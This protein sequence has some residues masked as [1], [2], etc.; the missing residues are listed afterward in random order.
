MT[1]FITGTGT[2]IGKTWVSCAILRALRAG[3]ATP[4][5]LKPVMSGFDPDHLASS[6]AGALLAA[7]ETEVSPDSVAAI[8]PWRFAAPLSPD[9]AAA[10]EGRSVDVEALIAF[11]RM[12]MAEPGP[13]LIEGVGG[14][15]VPLDTTSTVRDWIAALGI[16][17]LLVAG[18]YLGTISHT[19]CAVEALR[20]RDIPI[21]G[22]AVNAIAEPPMPVAETIATISRHLGNETIPVVDAATADW[23]S[24]VPLRP[25]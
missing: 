13:L 16:P 11:C 15:M 9:A 8:A 21:A 19:L 24:L 22:I 25:V 6:D 23:T 20:A 1:L 10:R 2:E 3:G 12:A 18:A 5:A 7:L 17:A 14:A 4:R